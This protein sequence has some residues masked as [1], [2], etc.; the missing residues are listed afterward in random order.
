MYAPYDNRTKVRTWK[1]FVAMCEAMRAVDIEI[2]ARL[3]GRK[4]YARHKTREQLKQE[5]A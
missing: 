3:D 1:E 5:V 4:A 2:Q